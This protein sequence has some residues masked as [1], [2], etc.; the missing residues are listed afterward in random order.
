MYNLK[1]DDVRVQFTYVGIYIK[2][3]VISNNY[4]KSMLFVAHTSNV[5]ASDLL[6]HV[7]KLYICIMQ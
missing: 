2:Y 1:K 5:V 4:F 3:K 7:K 6:I